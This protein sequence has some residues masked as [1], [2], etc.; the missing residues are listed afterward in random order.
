VE[1]H[2]LPDIYEKYFVESS[3]NEL[4]DSVDNQSTID[5]I[6]ETHVYSQLWYLLSQFYITLIAFLL[7]F[8][9]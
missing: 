1:C 2:S 8:F 6:T 4:F 3:V 5:F 9:L 7:Y